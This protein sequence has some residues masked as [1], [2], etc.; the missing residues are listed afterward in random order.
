MKR[1]YLFLT[2]HDIETISFERFFLDL[3]PDAKF[4]YS[5]PKEG[6]FESEEDKVFELNQKLSLNREMEVSLVV[7]HRDW[8]LEKK[9]LQEAA[10]YFPNQCVYLTDV[11]MKELTFGNF[12]SI[13]LL[14]SEFRHVNKELMSTAGTFLRSGL[15]GLKTAEAENIHR[16]TFNYRLN[17]FIEVTGLDIRDYHNAL[18]LELYFQLASNGR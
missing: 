8:P 15:N 9:L 4:T 7:S 2:S 18:L 14:S 6:Y 13:P 5:S 1:L 11:I 17:R 10:G 16:N 3:F 12:S